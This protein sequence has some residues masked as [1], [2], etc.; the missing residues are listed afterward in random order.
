M[1]RFRSRP[2]G[3]K[4]GAGAITLLAIVMA[5]SAIPATAK[6]PSGTPVT[7]GFLNPDQG[8]VASAQ[9]G[10]GERAAVARINA[11]G[12]IKGRPLKV[13]VCHTDATP[14][15]VIACANRFVNEHV[16]AVM[17]GLENATGAALPVLHSA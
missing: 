11:N 12:G 1:Q 9:K 10:Q 16:V 8:P 4:T 17:D 15:K 7:I 5:L 3:L 13:S 14:E 6:K 2:R